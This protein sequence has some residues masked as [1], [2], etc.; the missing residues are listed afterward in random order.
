M[1]ANDLERLAPLLATYLVHSTLWI[2]GCGVLLWLARVRNPAARHTAWKWSV[3]AGFLTAVSQHVLPLASHRF[4][5]NLAASTAPVLPI[6]QPLHASKSAAVVSTRADLEGPQ[7]GKALVTGGS[8]ANAGRAQN[9]VPLDEWES[10]IAGSAPLEK[11]F[12]SARSTRTRLDWLT[13]VVLLWLASVLVLL[14]RM[15]MGWRRLGKLGDLI[16]LTDGKQREL[17]DRLLSATKIRRRVRLFRSRSGTSPMAWGFWRWRI[18]VPSSLVE[19]LDR[20]ELHALLAHE[21]AHL[22]RG[23]TRWL[24]AWSVLS[25]VGCLQPLN[26]F[27]QRQIRRTAEL[28]SDGWAAK[29]TGDRLALARALTKTAELRGR[30][31]APLASLAMASPSALAERVDRLIENEPDA[32]SESK[33]SHWPIVVVASIAIA[34]AVAWMPGVKLTSAANLT[35]QPSDRIEE[36]RPAAEDGGMKALDQELAALD[37]EIGRLQPLV[38]SRHTDEP[39]AEAWRAIEER[40]AKVREGHTR[41]KRLRE[42][43]TSGTNSRAGNP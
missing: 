33:R 15:L 43:V 22:A 34:A 7:D 1:A 19:Q 37:A 14:G 29:A 31:A 12:D 42:Q 2:G 16:E 4:D 40:R 10:A 23:D 24:C 36:V 35:E 9:D 41:L 11:S 27:A 28:L 18:A 25:A 3:I 5:W 30:T 13:G 26:R 21:L 20:R 38:A 6:A 8:T 17:L 32:R 39:M